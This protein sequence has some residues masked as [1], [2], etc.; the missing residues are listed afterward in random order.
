MVILFVEMQ[1]MN[2]SGERRNERKAMKIRR[3]TLNQ[4]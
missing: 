3:E 4:Y 2:K 1:K